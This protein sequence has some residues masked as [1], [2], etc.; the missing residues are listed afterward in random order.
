MWDAFKIKNPY[1]AVE[2]AVAKVTAFSLVPCQYG[3]L[4][5]I[6]L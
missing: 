4:S 3:T 6:M 1:N 2:K 5:I